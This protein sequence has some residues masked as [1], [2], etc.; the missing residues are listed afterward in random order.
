MLPSPGDTSG[1][2]GA[3]W[4]LH[5]YWRGKAA[6][7]SIST[8]IGDRRDGPSTSRLVKGL[9]TP[10]PDQGTKGLCY[11]W[12]TPHLGLCG[13]TVHSYEGARGRSLGI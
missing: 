3:V 10:N 5:P 2:T 12:G 13:D 4:H 11:Y 7:N 8:P 9:S 6:L 1:L